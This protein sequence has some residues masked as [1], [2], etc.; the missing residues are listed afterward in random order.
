MGIWK[1]FM[2]MRRVGLV[3]ATPRLVAAQ[4]AGCAPIA[5]AFQAGDDVVRPWAVPKTVASGIQD[6]LVGYSQ[7]GTLT[8]RVVRKSD[9]LAVASSDEAILRGVRLMS[10]LEGLYVEPTVGAA[11]ATVPELVHR[12][13][14]R[15]DDEV[16]IVSTGHGLKQPFTSQD[17]ISA[18]AEIEPTLE[19][20]Q[21]LTLS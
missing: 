16:V 20:L 1:G 12:G 7:D 21:A 2:E 19:S 14:I 8:L 15:E 4:A 3:Q 13:A 9:G 17:E 5:R 6:P 18:L 11:V 10:Q